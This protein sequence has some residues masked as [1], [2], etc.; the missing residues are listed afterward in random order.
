MK[1]KEIM[2]GVKILPISILIVTAGIFFYEWYSNHNFRIPDQPNTTFSDAGEQ[3]T[4]DPSPDSQNSA[5]TAGT[6]ESTQGTQ[7]I[8]SFATT[9]GVF[10]RQPDTYQIALDNYRDHR[11]QFD[12][13]T[14]GIPATATFKGGTTIMVEGKSYDPQ[15]IYLGKQEI[16]LA[17]FDFALVTLPK[18]REKQTIYVGCA[19]N[20]MR[21][22]NVATVSVYP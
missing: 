13:C 6:Q 21:Y 1:M 7:D 19:V 11:L 4:L 5:T 15:I 20:D 3:N 8:I 16:E 10:P 9:G 2:G 12:N 14:A 17:G 22:Y 18:V